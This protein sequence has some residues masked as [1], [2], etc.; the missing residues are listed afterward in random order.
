M[1]IKPN[2][3][4]G[5]IA[6]HMRHSIGAF[7]LSATLW[8]LLAHY[9][10]YLPRALPTTPFTIVG[11]ALAIF[12]AFRTNSAYDR[13]WEGRK[14]WGA[15]VNTS[16]TWARQATTFIEAPPEADAAQVSAVERLK[17][18]LVR[19]Q[20]A[21]VH[22][23]RCHLRDGHDPLTDADC[24][25]FLSDAERA[26]L[27]HE[28]NIPNAIAQLQAEELVAAARQGWLHELRLQRMDASLTDLLNIQGGCERIKKTPVP[29]AYTYFATR[30][31]IWYGV[32]LPLVFAHELYWFAIPLTV[33]VAMC[34]RVVDE[35]GRLIQD[36]FTLA[37]NGLPLAALSKTIELNL[38]Q[39]IGEADPGPMPQPVDGILM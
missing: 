32:L 35:I 18:R 15:L 1:V 12:L 26:Q 39:R 11:A 2:L 5:L 13:W 19:R 17:E 22:A 27:A 30:I 24:T 20:I 14:L 34:F 3:P 6:W 10:D 29:R 38:R 28:N 8:T 4:I 25:S 37:V 33:A 21:Y 23:L 16:R 9:T 7:A 31:V 36:P